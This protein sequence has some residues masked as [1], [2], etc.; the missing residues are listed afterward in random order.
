MDAL[1][2]EEMDLRQSSTGLSPN[3]DLHFLPVISTCET[4]KTHVESML[5]TI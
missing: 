5:D 2:K 3:D 4:C 1:I